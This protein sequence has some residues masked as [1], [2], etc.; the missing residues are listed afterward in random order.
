MHTVS[1]YWCVVGGEYEL[2]MYADGRSYS[3]VCWKCTLM[4]VVKKEM[5]LG[6]VG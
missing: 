4:L 1:V 6:C 5:L 3:C 2:D